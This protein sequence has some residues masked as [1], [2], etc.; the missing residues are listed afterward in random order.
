M[1]LPPGPGGLGATAQALCTYAVQQT[2]RQI[3]VIQELLQHNLF[4]QFS[5]FFASICDHP[6]SSPS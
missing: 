3:H 2:P 5:S 6:D 4:Q 1:F